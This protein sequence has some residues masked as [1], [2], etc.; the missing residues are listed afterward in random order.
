MEIDGVFFSIGASFRAGRV[1]GL[2][3]SISVVI[4]RDSLGPS[5]R[6]GSASEPA[7]RAP[8]G[9]LRCSALQKRG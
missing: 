7:L 3:V 6:G 2:S 8:A 9:V 4:E 5:P 1:C